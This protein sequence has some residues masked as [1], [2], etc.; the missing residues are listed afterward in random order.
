ML[1]PFITVGLTAVFVL[2]V[3][4][5][6]LIRKNLKAKMKTVVYPGLFFIAT[7]TVIYI[8]LLK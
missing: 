5:L 7:W 3:L 8:L 2:Y 4:Y 1:Y 6:G